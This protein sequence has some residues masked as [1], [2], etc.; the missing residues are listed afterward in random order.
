MSRNS[1]MDSLKT[2][3]FKLLIARDFLSRVLG[4]LVHTMW[5][6]ISLAV[7]VLVQSTKE[8]FPVA[9]RHVYHFGEL[10]ISRVLRVIVRCQPVLHF[11]REE[12]FL[13]IA[14]LRSAFNHAFSFLWTI[15][16]QR[17]K[18]LLVKLIPLW[19]QLKHT[20]LWCNRAVLSV[21]RLVLKD[22]QNSYAWLKGIYHRQTLKHSLDP[23]SIRQYGQQFKEKSN[24]SYVIG[25]AQRTYRE[26]CVILRDHWQDFI[27]EIQAI[28]ARLKLLRKPTTKSRVVELLSPFAKEK[29]D[30]LAS[31]I[32]INTLALAF[33]LL[34]L[35]LYDRILPHQSVDTLFIFAIVVGI[36]VVIESYVRSLRSSLTSW[37]AARFEH[38][39]MLA[40]TERFLSEPLHLF[41]RK[42]TGAIM[43]DYKSIST[44]KYHYS[45]QTFQQLMDLPFTV[46]YVLIAFLINFWIGLL[47]FLGYTIFIFITWKQG[48]EAPLLAK[49][50][51]EGDLRRA[52]FLNEILKN[53][54]TLKSITMEALMQRRY[55]RLQEACAKLMSKITYST[56]ITTGIGNVF[57]PLMTILV[58]ALGAYLVVNGKMTNGELAACI[59]LGMRSLAPLQRLGS[60]WSKYQQDEILRDKLAG[61][62]KNPGLIELQILDDEPILKAKELDLVPA[63]ITLEKIRYRFHHN[64]PDVF[65]DLNLIIHPGEFILL[66]GSSGSGRST[67]MQLLSGQLQPDFG[68]IL[69]DGKDVADFQASTYADRVAYLSSNAT[70]FE[71]TLLDNITVFDPD[72]MT[73]A[74]QL[75]SQLGL[76]E[77]VA[78][79]PRGWDTQIGDMATETL[80]PGYRQRI[81]IVRALASQPN[82]ILFDNASSAMDSEGDKLLLNLIQSFRGKVT[83]VMVTNRQAFASIS[84]RI[85]YLRDGR[86][87]EAEDFEPHLVTEESVGALQETSALGSNAM[88]RI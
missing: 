60:I 30:V 16:P 33:P 17:M 42:G 63:G 10:M 57:S 3:W 38:N 73:I 22:M 50:Q 81:S 24:K 13:F 21:L 69:L 83:V 53:I 32:I 43:E 54:H 27:H 68:Q 87:F 58:T 34:M 29:R 75:S 48:R 15:T 65:N 7:I 82:V 11:L 70:L 45:G 49:Q 59:L 88:H 23:Y 84:N 9:W 4:R 28:W 55:E 19:V 40:L 6:W 8:Y 5:Q 74:L 79:L 46:V 39:A 1:P 47:L 12:Y 36:A 78:K 62:L 80:S 67:L 31:S 71:G 86:A 56:D 2:I 85:I 44:L 25:L 18:P 77:F 26:Y 51:K 66:G 52:N 72:R 35:Q 64:Q 41:E 61:N 37:I 76:S 14:L 20:W